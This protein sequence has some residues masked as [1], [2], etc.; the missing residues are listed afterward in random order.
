[1][2]FLEETIGHIADGFTSGRGDVRG[3][4]LASIHV[5]D[6][7]RIVSR[8]GVVHAHR[9]AEQVPCLRRWVGGIDP[10]RRQRPFIPDPG[11]ALRASAQV[12]TDR[13]CHH[14][15]DRELK[16]CRPPGPSSNAEPRQSTPTRQE[17]H[18]EEATDQRRGIVSLGCVLNAQTVRHSTKSRRKIGAFRALQ[19]ASRTI[20]GASRDP[21][22]WWIA[23]G[24]DKTPRSLGGYHVRADSRD[25][26][27][28]SVGGPPAR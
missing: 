23:V 3:R 12:A 20:R 9:E 4:V 10:N 7:I 22:P 6:R 1:M 5:A 26:Y 25:R 13:E 28:W 16:R 15:K 19:A 14:R 24:K 2:A 27:R 21:W 18:K 17:I 8:P 11:N